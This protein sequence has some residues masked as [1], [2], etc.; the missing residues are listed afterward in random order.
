MKAKEY[1]EQAVNGTI[2]DEERRLR[3][4]RVATSLFKMLNLDLSDDDDDND[5]EDEDVKV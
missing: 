4:E 1:R 3:A 2:D 5:E